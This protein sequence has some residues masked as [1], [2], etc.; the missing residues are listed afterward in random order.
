MFSTQK[1]LFKNTPEIHV[2]FR[3]ITM[4]STNMRS[5]R[6]ARIS[7]L[8]ATE[9]FRLTVGDLGSRLGD[10]GKRGMEKRV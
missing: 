1:N 10:I 2:S 7:V 5:D 4:E 8:T 3:K 9:S 6:K